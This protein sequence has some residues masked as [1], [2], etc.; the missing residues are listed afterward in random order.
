VRNRIYQLAAADKDRL[1]EKRVIRRSEASTDDAFFAARG[2]YGLTQASRETRQGFRELYLSNRAISLHIRDAKDYLDTIYPSSGSYAVPHGTINTWLTIRT[3]A[4]R[5][6]K[7]DVPIEIKPL[8]HI[9][10]NTP[11]LD[12]EF[13]GKGGAIFNQLFVG[14]EA[15]W[16]MAVANEFKNV[17]LKEPS[18]FGM[19]LVLDSKSNSPWVKQIPISVTRLPHVPEDTLP[20]FAAL[21]LDIENDMIFVRRGAPK[22]M[23]GEFFSG[24]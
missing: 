19:R 15:E 10:F 22:W 2:Y 9:L 13:D 3:D 11:G 5:R 17:E 20:W 24:K 16:K 1:I 4:E 23:K 6:A 21:G 7:Y 14:Y 8:L 18:M 12:F